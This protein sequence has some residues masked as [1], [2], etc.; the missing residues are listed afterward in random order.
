M[1]QQGGGRA[2]PPPHGLILPTGERRES[3][4]SPAFLSLLLKKYTFMA[5]C[6]AF[7]AAEWGLG[8]GN[9]QGNSV[10]CGRESW[11][12]SALH[13]RPR[14]RAGGTESPGLRPQVVGGVLWGCSRCSHPTP[15]QVRGVP[16]PRG[17]P[18]AIPLCT[19]APEMTPCPSSPAAPGA[20]NATFPVPSPWVSSSSGAA[21]GHTGR[22]APR[23]PSGGNK[24]ANALGNPSFSSGDVKSP[25]RWLWGPDAPER[26]CSS[27]WLG[28]KPGAVAAGRAG[29]PFIV[30]Q[31][32][33][34]P[35]APCAAA[36]EVRYNSQI[37]WGWA[38]PEKLPI[39]PPTASVHCVK[40]SKVG[41]F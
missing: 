10:V 14:R 9:L 1:W 24:T 18:G 26:S 12:G 3:A 27:C 32:L 28:H 7:P 21:A 16:P 39:P 29:S 41:F 8:G 4:E 22:G 23:G 6:V 25:V 37:E 17:H 36:F 33:P 31:N 13:P 34:P 19:A 38:Q 40:Y 35:L 20:G 11:V 15:P 30:R 2:E 5:L